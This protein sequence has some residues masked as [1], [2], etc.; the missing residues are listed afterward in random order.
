MSHYNIRMLCII[1]IRLDSKE[2][3]ASDSADI[4]GEKNESNSVQ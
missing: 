4:Y 2:A 1:R 3:E